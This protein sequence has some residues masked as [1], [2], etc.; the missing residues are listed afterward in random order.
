MSQ[1]A[2]S[3][4]MLTGTG[5]AQEILRN[6]LTPADEFIT[7]MEE[8][9]LVFKPSKIKES[10]KCDSEVLSLKSFP[11]FSGE[12]RARCCCCES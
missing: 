3:V 2:S 6:P 10:A 5:M 4:D 1:N 8:L 11:E 9:E 7:T 12:S